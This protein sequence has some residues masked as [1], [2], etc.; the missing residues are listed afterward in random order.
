MAL[1]VGATIVIEDFLMLSQGR[2]RNKCLPGGDAEQASVLT[3]YAALAST[4]RFDALPRLDEAP[5]RAIL[6]FGQAFGLLP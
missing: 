3:H 2:K 1:L 4:Y 5:R 6:F